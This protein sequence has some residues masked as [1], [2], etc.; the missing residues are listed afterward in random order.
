MPAAWY[1]ICR[2]VLQLLHGTASAAWY[3]ICR[4]VLHLPHGTPTAAWYRICR[5][6]LH[7]PHGTSTAAWY[8]ICRMVPHLSHGT[9]S[10]A[11]YRIAMSS[12][13]R[14]FFYSKEIILYFHCSKYTKEKRERECT[15]ESRQR[16]SRFN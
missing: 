10:V 14:F 12:A 6:V 9:A 3:Y 7:L 8:R 13:G 4:M 16:V 11:W 5:M 2:E 15:T 1:Y